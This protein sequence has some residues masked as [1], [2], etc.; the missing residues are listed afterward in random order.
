MIKSS[1]NQEHLS[2]CVLQSFP[3]GPFFVTEQGTFV[4]FSPLSFHAPQGLLPEWKLLWII[5]TT[6]W[7]SHQCE[8]GGFNP[9]SDSLVVSVMYQMESKQH[10]ISK[11]TRFDSLMGSAVRAEWGQ[12]KHISL[13]GL[14]FWKPPNTPKTTR[15][16]II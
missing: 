2:S 10:S 3:P 13:L 6:F 12:H 5:D 11:N 4:S 15:Q 7:I 8:A 9:L 16:E 14:L 1:F